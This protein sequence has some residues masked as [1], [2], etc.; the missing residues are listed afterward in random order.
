MT[1]ATN[2]FY[3]SPPLG[4]SRRLGPLTR[5]G[6]Y[7]DPLAHPTAFALAATPAG[8]SVLPLLLADRANHT[9]SSGP[10]NASAAAATETL[11]VG[12]GLPVPPA[13][14]IP[15]VT[16]RAGP[17][18]AASTP[19]LTTSLKQ[20]ARPGDKAIDVA[21][22]AGVEAGMVVTIGAGSGSGEGGA[23]RGAG[24][25][26]VVTGLGSILLD[27]PLERPHGAGTVVNVYRPP[28]PARPTTGASGGAPGAAGDRMP[29][30][31]PAT[32]TSRGLLPSNATPLPASGASSPSSP[33]GPGGGR[34]VG[35]GKEYEEWTDRPG[36]S[37]ATGLL[38]YAH[39]QQE[40]GLE[41]LLQY[42]L[43]LLAPQPRLETRPLTLSLFYASVAV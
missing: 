18:T 20:P 6:V 4:T 24:E 19:V 34:G 29:P 36:A 26:R 25:T 11:G 42:L 12:W 10:G 35:S 30:L 39:K 3:H 28:A 27:R 5:N 13:A 32:D 9:P 33:G 7:I 31:T 37:S 38:P 41:S 2:H 22:H 14:A 8:G 1:H 15:S 16:T 23:G 17:A 21:S 40:V 43:W